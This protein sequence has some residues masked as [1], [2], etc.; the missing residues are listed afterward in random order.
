MKL[1]VETYDPKQESVATPIPSITVTDAAAAQVQTLLDEMDDEYEGL[2][3]FVQG[4]GCSG[5][6]YGFTFDEVVNEDDAVIEQNGINFIIDELS[7][8]YLVGSIIDYTVEIA[9]ARF[10]INNPNV[11]STCGCGSS[12]GV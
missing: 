12:F 7:Y 5:F 3:I 9:G 6:Q 4:G 2:R 10:V 1:E 11:Q 8:Q